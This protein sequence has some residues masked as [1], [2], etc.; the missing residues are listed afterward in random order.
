MVTSSCAIVARAS[1]PQ[2]LVFRAR[3]VLLAFRRWSNQA[4]AAELDTTVDTVRKWRRRYIRD[5]LP[6]LADRS[7]SGR[8]DTYGPDVRL[9]VVATATSLPP[10]GESQRSHRRIAEQLAPPPN[11]HS[12]R[13][14]DHHEPS[15]TT[16]EGITRRCTSRRCGWRIREDRHGYGHLVVESLTQP[17]AAIS[18]TADV[19]QRTEDSL[20]GDPV[21]SRRSRAAYSPD[22][23]IASPTSSLVFGP[24]ASAPRAEMACS[25]RSAGYRPG[26]LR[27][28]ALRQVPAGRV[29]QEIASGGARRR[30]RQ[31][32][33]LEACGQLDQSCQLRP[34][35]RPNSV[36]LAVTTVN[37]RR[38]A[39][40]AI[41]RS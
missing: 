18:R 6:G 8:P 2:R 32:W 23:R 20:T 41:S 12:H 4:I 39:W 27:L 1:S 14:P 3:I 19:Q 21:I 15:P 7:R 16:H 10:D 17:R 25:R 26:G 28:P 9:R 22:R 37:P 29:P 38:K 13:Q 34:V 11:Q 40:P 31:G 36:V 30:Y 35:T 24:V 33:P 5:G